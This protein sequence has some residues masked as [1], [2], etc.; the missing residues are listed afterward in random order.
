MSP[1]GMGLTTF[2][3]SIL[4]YKVDVNRFIISCF[5]Y[6]LRRNFEK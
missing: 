4:K 2:V 3:I 5:G 1:E 6:Y